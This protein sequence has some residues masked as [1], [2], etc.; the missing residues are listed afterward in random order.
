M[1]RLAAAHQTTLPRLLPLPP[2]HHARRPR[3]LPLAAP[4]LRPPHRTEPSPELRRPVPLPR[5]Q[6]HRRLLPPRAHPPPARRGHQCQLPRRPLRARRVLLPIHPRPHHPLLRPPLL[7]RP[8]LPL[9]LLSRPRRHLLLPVAGDL[10]Q[11]PL[12]GRRS[13]D[14]P[15][16]L[17]LRRIRVGLRG[18]R[19]RQ[20]RP[21]GGLRLPRLP[22]RRRRG[23]GP[24]RE[25]PLLGHRAQRARGGGRCRGG[26]HRPAGVRRRRGEGVVPQRAVAAAERRAG[27]EPV[28]GHGRPDDADVGVL[29]GL[30]ASVEEAMATDDM[31]LIPALPVSARD[32]MEVHRALGGAVAPADWQGRGDG[33]VYRLGPGPA[34]LNLTYIG[35]DAMATIENVF[36]V[37]EGAEEPDR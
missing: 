35:N 7:P 13:G 30:R 18:G 25:D 31:P 27:R 21:R 9:P 1:S 23:Q 33:P 16:L 15:D 20:L 3:C 32:E 6:R 29:G 5:L 4:L 28:P 17:H 8:P 11:R 26:V 14:H 24:V 36:A 37:I 2:L 34:V 12:S 22:R 10:P 19:V